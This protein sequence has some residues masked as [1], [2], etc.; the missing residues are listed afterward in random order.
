MKKI[1]TFFYR[2]PSSS[3]RTNR[4]F[5][6]I[7]L[8]LIALM[9]LANSLI[10][11]NTVFY[12]NFDR[13]TYTSPQTGGTP[14]VT[15][16]S[17]S[18]ATTPGIVSMKQNSGSDY[19][20]QIAGNGAS[21]NTFTYLDNSKFYNPYSASAGL[22]NSS[23]II[24]W[25]F[26]TKYFNA[27]S[28]NYRQVIVLAASNSDFNNSGCVGYAVYFRKTTALKFSLAR[29][30][31]G[32]Q[33]GITDVIPEAT[34]ADITTITDYASVK[35]TYD[36]STGNWSM[37]VRD[38]GATAYAT[39]WTGTY[40]TQHGSSVSDN[41]YTS[42]SYNLNYSGFY[43][44]HT[45][46]GTSS[47]YRGNFDNFRVDQIASTAPTTQASSLTYSTIATSSLTASWTKG[48]GYKRIVKI[49]TSNS[50]TNP[51]DGSE[52][53]S[54]SVYSGSGEQIVYDGT[55]NSVNVTG[56]SPNTQ[57]YFR[58][59]EYYYG[60]SLYPYYQTS[61]STDN[62]KNAT[63][64]SA[65]VAPTIST[66][67]LSTITNSSATLG[68]NITSDGGSAITDRGTVWKTI[69]G[70]TISDNFLSEGGITT[71]VFS[72][73]RTSLPAKSQIFYKAYATNSIGTSLTSESNFFT[74]ANEPTSTVGSFAANA[75]SGSSTSLNLSWTAATGADG[76][77]IIQK[78]GSAAAGTAP[79]D[80]AA[81]TVGAALGTGIIAAVVTS[82]ISQTITGLTANTQYTF[83]IYPF[84]YDGA[85]AQT[86]N[87][88]AIALASSVTATTKA[89]PTISVSGTQSF[90]Y[91][92][93]AQGPAI[94][95][96]NGDGSTSLA[97]TSTDGGGYS[98]AITPTNAGAYQVVVSATE[99]TNYIAGTSAA[100]TFTIGKATPTVT[101]TIGI[102]TY[103]GSAQGPNAATTGGSTG[104]VTYSYVSTDGT[105]YPASA[106]APT[107]A[108][109]YT[110]TA[111][112][113]ADANYN[114]ASSAAT[115]FT[116]AYA[117]VT[118]TT[119]T[120]ISTLLTSSGTDITVSSGEL[121][122]DQ[123]ASVK[124]ITVAPGRKLTL[125]SGKTL[126]VVGTL[127]LQSDVSGTATF[128]DNGG[129]LTTG[130]TNIQQYLTAGRN[131]YVS[132]PV[133]GAKSDVFSASTSY[134]LYWYDE[135]NASTVP[136][137]TITDTNT[138]L[139]ATQ[140]YVA[141]MAADG[142]VTF[143]GTLN[144][145]DIPT[146][147][148]SR[149][150][151]IKTGFNLIGNPYPSYVSW[152]DATKTK[153]LTSIWYRS[154][155]TGSYVFQTYNSSDQ[156]G[157]LGG[158]ELIPPMQSFW[159]LTDVTQPGDASVTFKNATRS[160]QDQSVTSNRMKAP[161]LNAQQVLR[162]QV[163]NAVNSDEAI[164]LFNSN[165]S[166]GLD[167]YDSE[168]MSNNNPA[169]PEI[170]TLAG[171][172]PVAINGLNN[173]ATNPVMPLGFTT[174]AS[175][176]FT[177][178]A[179]EISNFDSDTKII[180]KDNVLNT[181]QDLTNG[182]VYTFASDV[183]STTSR[184][185]IVFKSVGVTTGVQAASGDPSILIYKNANNRIA[186]NCIGSISDNAYVSVY[187]TLGQKLDLKKMAGTTTIIDKAF[188]SG[189]YVVTVNN[190][191]TSTTRKVIIN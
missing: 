71:G 50:F 146:P 65:A 34:T 114:S 98:S 167:A 31:G 51:T 26:N 164:V 131:W 37:Y 109:S 124:S 107:A 144:T 141:N 63:T 39:P 42:S 186:V 11:Q 76:Y 133:T 21:G 116:I 145:G 175:N 105:T 161:A 68:G 112:V 43:Y 101:P 162:L 47:N 1:N 142:A 27:S 62:P 80:A 15:Y 156:V 135:A 120:N 36:P 160:H 102:Y 188:T 66:P 67:T 154:K 89:S 150:G 168:K 185:S 20:L 59:Y 38:D 73:S 103:T 94:I 48:N 111:T 46:T 87:Y 126:S 58:V 8:T 55:D 184:F 138:R 49:N 151:T 44:I 104:T 41:T 166:D 129:A 174:G 115:A 163:S 56:L 159:V 79:T 22:V 17:N 9:P 179:T 170:Y 16:T 108:G 181:E 172:F 134:P 64:L 12:D 180:L 93:F 139:N 178:K 96:Y 140:G 84:G 29:F 7:F 190:G 40:A 173:M 3:I 35:V 99:G 45:G 74:L 83:R 88:T 177:I 147:T 169:I 32:V 152:N 13:S 127:T 69:T 70:V 33:S 106:T 53:T 57:Y 5:K 6:F 125:A 117:S 25:Y 97:Y 110:V 86:F 153:V 95:T 113:T 19:S 148:L 189:V 187:N 52:P 81:Y 30:S 24:T 23:G 191:G 119:N 54:N 122:I 72:H 155:S 137:P 158:T 78:A 136:W 10:G 132:S 90:T 183:A 100:Y 176:T 92:G 60:A 4:V 75:V 149:S 165:A 14:S 118:V 171:T 18:T 85:N 2:K 128:V 91:T 28:T 130:S 123:A 157:T 82:G 77:I 61:T 121:I 182:V 143:S